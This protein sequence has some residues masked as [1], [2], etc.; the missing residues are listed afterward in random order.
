MCVCVCAYTNDL[1]ISYY[2]TFVA[3]SDT[4][5]RERNFENLKVEQL[6]VCVCVCLC[7]C[8]CAQY[9]PQRWMKTALLLQLVFMIGMV[10]HSHTQ[11][12]PPLLLTA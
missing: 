3:H 11:N 4:I 6:C 1:L 9:I 10:K 8:V 2:F 5:Q 12:T 7:A